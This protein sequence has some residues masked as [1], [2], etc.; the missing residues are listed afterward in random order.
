[1]KVV[2]LIALSALAAP[3]AAQTPLPHKLVLAWSVGGV[4]VVDYPSA[5]RCAAAKR[6][7]D[8]ERQR[9]ISEAE[10]R[11][12]QSGATLVGS[13]WVVSGFCIPG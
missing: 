6:A 1:M 5:S 9:R 4:T 7:V 10:D 3:V 12:A 13:P 8:E 2:S 11:A